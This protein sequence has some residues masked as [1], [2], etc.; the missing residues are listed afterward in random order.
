MA[1]LCS[2]S[3]NECVPRCNCTSACGALI[4]NK[5]MWCLKLCSVL[6]YNG[7][8]SLQSGAA[9]CW[10]G[11]KSRSCLSRIHLCQIR[12][13]TYRLL[14]SQAYR[15]KKMDKYICLLLTTL[16]STFQSAQLWGMVGREWQPMHPVICKSSVAMWQKAWGPMA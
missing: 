15:C 6:Y 4:M 10:I 1:W 8:C 14:I 5:K 13:C 12:E 11:W 2:L 9:V 3:C 7:F 16:C